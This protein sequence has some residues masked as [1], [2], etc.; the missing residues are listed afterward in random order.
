MP[1]MRLAQRS[2]YHL[3]IPSS[4]RFYLSY[5]FSPFAS[6][7][8]QLLYRR[9]HSWFNVPLLVASSSNV[10]STFLAAILTYRTTDPRIKQFFTAIWELASYGISS[11]FLERTLN[12]AQDKLLA[13]TFR[14]CWTLIPELSPDPFHFHP[15]PYSTETPRNS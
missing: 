8:N 1:Y 3:L 13:W 11:P 12:P 14:R 6:V 10:V 2:P 9:P 7:Y 5:F 4:K 15:S